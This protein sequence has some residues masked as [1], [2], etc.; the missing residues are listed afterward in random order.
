[1]NEH[2]TIA[3]I[4]EESREGMMKKQIGVVNALYPTPTVLVGATVDGRPN[5]ITIAYVGIMTHTHIS[6][7][8]GKPHH[9]NG[10]IK[11]NKTFSVCLPSEDLVVK[12]DYCGIM[13]GKRTDK[14]P[15]FDIFYGELKTAPM[16]Q[17]CKVCMECR[18][19]RIVDFST[20][21]VFVGEIV[22]TYADE[23]VLSD[24]KVDVSK[25]KPLLFDMGSRKYWS[26]G[27]EIAKCWDIGKQLTAGRS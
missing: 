26:L 12:T 9:T 25:L 8:M 1:M 19:D 20:H 7:G 6:L 18:L 14:A 4:S 24:G 10:G 27:N 2:T 17:Q 23:S 11:E 13:S 15:L 16:I 21:D 5:F 22:Q 3:P